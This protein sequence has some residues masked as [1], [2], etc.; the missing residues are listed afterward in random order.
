MFFNSLNRKGKAEDVVEDDIEV[1]ISIHN[2]M[3]EVTWRELEFWELLFHKEACE[4]PKLLK[5]R[6]RPDDFTPKARFNN[7]VRG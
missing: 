4:R 6:G 2:N 7:I 3:N 1:I 5:F